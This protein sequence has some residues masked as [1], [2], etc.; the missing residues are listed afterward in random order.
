MLVGR[1]AGVCTGK[2]QHVSAEE[3]PL[4]E[5][6]RNNTW[7]TWTSACYSPPPLKHQLPPIALDLQKLKRHALLIYFRVA[8][9][10]QSPA[11]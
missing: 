10:L 4:Q 7:L 8:Q 11:Q 9:R 3:T 6:H 2:V 5:E 1:V